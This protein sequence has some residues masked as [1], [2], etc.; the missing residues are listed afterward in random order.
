MDTQR[1]SSLTINKCVCTLPMYAHVC[2]YTYMYVYIYTGMGM[3]I[4][5]QT[6]VY[7]RG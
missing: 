2:I 7:R 6:H 5:T 1:A 4:Y 3:C